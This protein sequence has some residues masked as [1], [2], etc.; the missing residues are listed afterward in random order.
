MK[1][2]VLLLMLAAAGCATTGN[3]VQPGDFISPLDQRY[4][5]ELMAE[6]TTFRISRAEG[7]DAWS[8]AQAFIGR[9]AG[10][11]LQIHSEN[12]LQTYN[13][14]NEFRFAYY[15]TRSPIMDSVEFRVECIS[16]YSVYQ[17]RLNAHLCSR[18]IRTGEIK[19]RL[20]DLYLRCPPNASR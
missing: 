15:I 5:D 14:S 9:Y 12:I 4:V 19:E 7:P 16:D 2:I 8:R 18:Y 10:M 3:Y 13:P 1:R 20:L 6:P 17:R 11:K